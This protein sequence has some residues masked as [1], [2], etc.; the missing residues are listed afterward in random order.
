M[1]RYRGKVPAPFTFGEGQTYTTFSL[2]VKRETNGIDS[3]H[4]DGTTVYTTTV[5]NTGNI[6]AQQT[7]MVFARPVS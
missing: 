6:S 5:V 1:L 2:S 4:T 7:V 3:P